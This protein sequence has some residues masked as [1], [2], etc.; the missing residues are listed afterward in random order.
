MLF[1][2][3]TP[4]LSSL[5]RTVRDGLRRHVEVLAG[6]IGPRHI[7]RPSSAAAAVEYVARQFEALGLSVQRQ[8]YRATSSARA[9]NLA[10]EVRGATAPGQIVIIGAHHDTISNSPGANDNA[11]GIAAVLETARLTA[12]GT[13]G[14]TLRFVAFA[15]EEP[16]FFQTPQMGSRVYARS[17]GERDEDIVAM[18]CPE[19]IGYYADAPGT[20]RYPDG[21]PAPLQLL[22]PK[23]G[24]FLAVVGNRASRRLVSQVEKL[25]KRHA[26]FP[27]RGAALPEFI[28]GIGWSDHWSFWQE[29]YPAVMLTDTAPYRYPFYHSEEDTPDKLDYD[30]TAR[31]ITGIAHVT[32]EL[33]QGR[34]VGGQ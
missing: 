1:S 6:L 25:F 33:A 34:V 12:R 8:E 24:D 4:P 9:V 27:C 29:G 18:I 30:R 31:V 5:E 16:P 17:C 19:T 26:K 3:L 23:R 20:Q 13:P 7:G 14:R 10:C 15:N 22:L 11:T 32:A 21:V 2:P 28:T